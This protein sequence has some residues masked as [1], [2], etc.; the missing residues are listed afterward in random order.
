MFNPGVFMITHL[1]G[2]S[3]RCG[4]IW[5]AALLLVGMINQVP[6]AHAQAV[7]FDFDSAPLHSPLPLDLTAGGFT[8]HFAATGDGYSIQEANVLGFTPPG[9]AGYILYPNSIYLADLLIRFDRAISDFSIMYSVNELGC[10]TSA[11]MRVSAFMAGGF[12]GTNTMIA[13][14]PGTWPVDTLGFS[15]PLGFDS[16][17]VHYDSPPPSAWCADYGV[18]YLADNLRVTAL[19]TGVTDPRTYDEGLII[20]NPMIRSAT[21]SF[22]LR[23]AENIAL[24]C[25]WGKKLTSAASLGSVPQAATR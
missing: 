15:Y 21:I 17:V 18:V 7:L 16:V 12:V 11:T 9:F 8:A 1:M 23:Q 3:N 5:A 6:P 10:D 13:R 22:S 20:P 19:S 14:V 4:P 2:S 25:M 24:K